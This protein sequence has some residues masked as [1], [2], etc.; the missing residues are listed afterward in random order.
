MMEAR[1]VLVIAYYFPPM[2]LSGVQRTV[3]FVKYLPENGWN[4]I[5]LTT[6]PG[7]FYAFD[8]TLES[9]LSNENIKIYRTNSDVKRYSKGKKN[10]KFPS[11][12]KQKLGR[13]FLQTIY[14]PDSRKPWKKPALKLAAKILEENKIDV[15]LATAPPFTDFLIAREIS[16]KY[17]IPFVVDYRDVWIDNPFHFY[18]TPFHKSA[19]IKMESDILKHTQRAVVTTRRTKELLLRRYGFISHEDVTI[20][21][22]GYDPE[23]FE[24]YKDLKNQSDKFIITHSGLFQDDRTPKHFLKALSNFI[25]KNKDAEHRI[26]ARF[27]GLMRSSH[28]KLIKKYKLQNVVTTTGYLNHEESV[29]NLLESDVLWFVVNDT[30]RSPGKLYE[31]FGARKPI[32]ALAPE[33]VIRKTAIDSKAAIAVEPKDVKEI[34][35]A[36]GTFYKLW[37]H[38]TLPVPKEDFA[39]SFNR[40][41]LTKELAKELSLAVEL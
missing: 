23:D 14:Q 34:E 36:I 24:P 6:N 1:N 16:E 39:S 21:P 9:D 5:V 15:I 35:N 17:K 37:T 13:I 8:D 25:K 12:F 32:L 41:L 18:A 19:C 38:G 30:V 2:G 10:K 11:Y 28:L 33:G 4:P 40:R 26:E 31:Y 3:K 29:K 22:H 20:I 27:V 7:S